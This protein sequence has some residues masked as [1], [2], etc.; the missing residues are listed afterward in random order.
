MRLFQIKEPKA[1]SGLTRYR[2]RDIKST[3]TKRMIKSE[4]IKAIE[5]FDKNL[6]K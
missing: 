6:S 4:M 3:I 1:M 5:P 2:I